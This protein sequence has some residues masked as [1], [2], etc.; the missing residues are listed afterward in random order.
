M[1]RGEFKRKGR[2]P[3]EHIEIE[4]GRVAENKE[5]REERGT[6]TTEECCDT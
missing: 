4:R 5:R 3:R 2:E 6:R 1:S